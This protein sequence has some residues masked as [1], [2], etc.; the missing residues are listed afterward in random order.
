MLLCWTA[1]AD[2]LE[3]RW[4][5]RVQSDVRFRIQAKE[6]GAFYKKLELPAGVARN[7]NIFKAKLDALYGSYAGVVD[8]DFVWLGYPESLDGIADLSDRGFVDPYYLQVHALYLEAADFI[9]EGLDLRIGQ[10]QI[11]WGVGDQFNPTN[12]LNPNDVE[13]VLLFGEQMANLMIK[14]DYAVYDMWTVSGVLVPIFQPALLPRSAP[15][16]IAATDRYPFTD[17]QLRHRIRS[18]QQLSRLLGWPTAV[19]RAVPIM[20]D[21]SLENMQFAFRLAGTILDQ[22]IAVSYYRGR[23]DFPQPFLNYTVQSPFAERQCS[24]QDATDCV[25]GLLDTVTSLGYP[26]IQVVGLNLSGEVDLLGWMSDS[27]HPIGYR[28][29][30]A[31]VF[32]ERYT[33]GMVQEA[34]DFVIVTQPAGEYDYDGDGD[35]GGARPVVVDDI[36]FFKWVLGLDYSFGRHVYANL[37]WVHGLV[38]E[39]GIGYAVR[40]GESQS[41]QSDLLT[42]QT[43]GDFRTCNSREILRQRLGDYMVFGL[44]FKFLDDRLLLRL[45]SILDLTGIEEAEWDRRA[46]RMIKKHSSFYTEKGFSMVIYPELGYNFGNGLEVGLGVLLQLGEDYTK[47]GDPAAG[48]SLAWAR[49]RFSF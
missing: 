31:V 16:G 32:P 10:Q 24:P 37:M 47:F 6:T 39:F 35:P 46:Q 49:A 12:T 38:D 28:L 40:Q 23:T 7:E 2:E 8:V 42:C 5:G 33:I 36:P 3:L 30:L 34:M 43:S 44:D 27:I 41:D 48:G 29:E 21:K 1:A 17:E 18:E 13:D 14:L 9:F 15:L 22:D 45:F 11:K 25:N 20:P 19:D 26:E 4:G